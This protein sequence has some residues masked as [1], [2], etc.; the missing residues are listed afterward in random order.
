[1][2]EL[3]GGGARMCRCIDRERERERVEGGD[4]K[5]KGGAYS[6]IVNLTL[7]RQDDCLVWPLC[8]GPILQI[9]T[10]FLQLYIYKT[11]S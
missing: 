5:E 11:L 4:Y 1:M 7:R 9:Y 6:G 2:R 8:S 10:W 3:V